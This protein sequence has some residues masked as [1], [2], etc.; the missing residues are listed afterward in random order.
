M[1]DTDLDQRNKI[2]KH[3]TERYERKQILFDETD[4]I[5][6]KYVEELW[7]RI[8]ET[9]RLDTTPV[10]QRARMVDIVP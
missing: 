4:P 3:L 8:I 1:E 2:Q 9:K 10:E 5:V 6:R 7:K